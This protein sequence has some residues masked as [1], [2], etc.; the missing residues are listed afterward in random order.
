MD[1]AAYATTILDH[2]HIDSAGRYFNEGSPLRE[3]YKYTKGYNGGLVGASKKAY[4]DLKE[5]FN[6]YIHNENQ[7]RLLAQSLLNMYFVEESISVFDPGLQYNFSGINEYYNN[8]YLYT[9]DIHS[10]STLGIRFMGVEIS[11]LHFTGK[12][13]PFL[14]EENNQGK[15]I[16]NSFYNKGV[17]L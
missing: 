8:P 12:N 17:L 13:K 4:R 1:D 3:V 15:F 10:D 9:T 6:Y 14:N 16:W 5:G 11:V 2:A 7:F